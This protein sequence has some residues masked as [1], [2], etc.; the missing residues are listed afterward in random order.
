MRV[1]VF[2]SCLTEI[3]YPGVMPAALGVLGALGVEAVSLKGATCCG[4]AFMNS[5][6]P[7]MAKKVGRKLFR[8]ILASEDPVVFTSGSCAF[9]VR[10]HYPRLFGIGIGIDELCFEFTEFIARALEADIEGALK[11]P[12]RAAYHPACHLLRGLKLKD[13]PF[14][15]LS[16]IK[17]LELV[18]INK[19]ET[20][21]GFGGIF[22]A[23]YPEVSDR[24]AD[25]K[26]QALRDAG[27][28]LFVSTDAGCLRRVE[29]S[30]LKATHIAEILWAGMRP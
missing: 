4:Q 21:C 23:V 29:K 17:N 5:G 26:A 22:S 28:E 7:E 9:F 1:R 24:M 12:V 6:H 15:L 25:E 30:G 16:R 11:D 8:S 20:C 19:E 2:S 14:A 27:A 13:E 3:Y 10:E 18:R